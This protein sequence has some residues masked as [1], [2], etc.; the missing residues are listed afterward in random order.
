[1]K[2]FDIV[3][4][5]VNPAVDKSTSFKGLVAEQKIRCE[6]P[7][8]CQFAQAKR[9]ATLLFLARELLILQ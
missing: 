8:L 1:M 6:A 4:L 5:T 3:T 7:Q 9:H 2:A